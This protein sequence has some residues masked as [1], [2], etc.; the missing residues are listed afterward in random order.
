MVGFYPLVLA[1]G[2]KNTLSDAVMS[3]GLAHAM[4]LRV[5]KTDRRVRTDLTTDGGVLVSTGSGAGSERG[6]GGDK[7]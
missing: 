6:T 3:C 7:G 1:V 2:T 5:R 4:L